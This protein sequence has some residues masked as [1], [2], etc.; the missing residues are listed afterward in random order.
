MPYHHIILPLA[1][2]RD[3]ETEVRWG[4]ADFKRRFGRDPIGLWLPETAVDH[5]TLDVIARAGIAFTVLAP[6]QV[7]KSPERGFPAKIE[8]TYGR[9]IAGF[10]Y[11]GGCRTTS[12]WRFGDRCH[13]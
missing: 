3:K 7:S 4:I 13:R 6:H 5:E 2:R 10:V 1:N 12:H 11:N 8:L 9:S